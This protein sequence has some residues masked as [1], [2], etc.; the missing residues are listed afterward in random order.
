[1]ALAPDA[2]TLRG[3]SLRG[4]ILAE[5]AG[6]RRL[7]GVA[8]LTVAESALWLARKWGDTPGATW[9]DWR[10]LAG[11]VFRGVD[12]ARAMNNRPD[13]VPDRTSHPI[14]TAIEGEPFN[15]VYHVL[16]RHRAGGNVV[17]S[18]QQEVVSTVRLSAEQVTA[19]AL[20]SAEELSPKLRERGESL[21]S[22]PSGSVP[23][24]LI[25]AAGRKS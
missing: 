10:T 23:E 4:F 16:I 13:W 6:G 21:R 18:Y 25:L 12:L 20:A 19:R 7:G 2:A 15:Y 17:L 24:V 14:D 9:R 1:M 3:R 8:G 5:L 11:R 22:L